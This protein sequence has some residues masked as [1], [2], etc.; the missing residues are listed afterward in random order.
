VFFMRS[1][2][3]AGAPYPARLPVV[4]PRRFDIQ[5]SGEPLFSQVTPAVER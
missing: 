1:R 2:V 5:L 4:L 3:F